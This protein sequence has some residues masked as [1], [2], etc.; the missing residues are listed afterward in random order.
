MVIPYLCDVEK[1]QDLRMILSQNIRKARK[2]FRISQAKLAEFAEI[3]VPHMLDIEYRKTW[4]SDKTLKKIAD[5]LNMEPYELLIPEMPIREDAKSKRKDK[6][7]LRIAAIIKAK[8]RD[9]RK[10]EDEVI[11][12]LILEIMKAQGSN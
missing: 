3:S 9:L 8:R 12:S 1:T 5:A 4:V 7:L 10:K 6:T 2:L 11:D